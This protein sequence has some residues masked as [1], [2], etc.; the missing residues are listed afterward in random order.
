MLKLN[1][2]KESWELTRKWI[3]LLDKNIPR[4][5][6]TY[7]G[8]FYRG[9]IK[10]SS[11]NWKE[12]IIVYDEYEPSKQHRTGR[13]HF[14]EQ[15]ATRKFDSSYTARSCFL[16]PEVAQKYYNEHEKIGIY[17]FK[18]MIDWGDARYLKGRRFTILYEGGF[19]YDTV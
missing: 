15:A 19:E 2:Y 6:V 4:G 5:I 14:L 12:V 8:G 10:K 9:E 17:D 7:Y 3:K 11:G 16:T 1:Q 18:N 13:D